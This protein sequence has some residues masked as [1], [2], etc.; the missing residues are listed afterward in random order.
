MPRRLPARLRPGRGWTKAVLLLP[1]LLCGCAEFYPQSTLHPSSEFARNLAELFE[2]IFWWAVPVFVVVEGVLLYVI[3]RY[4]DAGGEGRAEDVHGNTKLEV[5]WTLAPAIILVFIAIPTIQT[6]FVVDNPP[7]EEEDALTVEVVGHQWWWEFR[8]PE[9]G[10]VTA[11]EPHIPVGRTV[12]WRLS[13]ADVIHSFWVPKLGG[14][15][16]LD[17][18]RET[19]LW[20]AADTA[21]VY[22]GQC[23]EFCGLQHANMGM[24][25][26]AQE[27]D[28]F[29]AWV[30]RQREPAAEPG[31]SLV[32]RG[33]EIFS[34]S[35]CLG[36][37]TVRGVTEVGEVGPDLTHIGSRRTLAAGMI[38][39][40]PEN[41][42]RWIEDPQE[43]KP[44]NL[45]P[46]TGMSAEQI[47]ALVAY[48]QSLR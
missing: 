1:L 6:I 15:R 19:M 12:L 47:E 39:N 35:A 31:D 14:K 9:L 22:W 8:Y 40:T 7:P 48:L 43:V 23:G 21:G 30:R 16:D 3:F 32:A 17:P 29:E 46:P 44:G 37:H 28:E 5:A 45:M 11:N 36:C 24:R 10:I 13:S 20:F 33:R 25:V 4:R 2:T 42:A 41:M 34:T 26:V 38:E 18:A 27:P